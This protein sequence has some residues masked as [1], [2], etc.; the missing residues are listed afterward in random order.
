ML[1]F[2]LKICLLFFLSEIFITILQ[3]YL[4]SFAIHL[5][6]LL[7][8]RVV[9]VM[10]LD[11]QHAVECTDPEKLFL[12]GATEEDVVA[13]LGLYCEAVLPYAGSPP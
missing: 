6:Y 12:V 2:F 10:E 4:L 13:L 7:R 3:N 8:D 9:C 11:T 5:M 1:F